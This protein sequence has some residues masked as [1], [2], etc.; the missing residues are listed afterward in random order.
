MSKIAYFSAEYSV[1]DSLP[2]YAGGLGILA[3][4]AVME[5]GSEKLDFHA[6][7]LVY[8]QAFT[9]GDDDQRPMEERL[10]DEGFCRVADVGGKPLVL[11]VRID[12]QK[13]AV[14]AWRKRFGATTLTLLDTDIAENPP[15]WRE[16]SQHLYD[17]RP[18]VIW[19]QQIVLGFGAV[20]LL[21]AMG[22]EPDIYHLNEG[23]MAMAGLA[24]AVR[25]QHLHPELT[26][27]QA[28]NAVKQQLV[29]TKHTIMHGAGLTLDRP[30]LEES[31]GP[32]LKDARG[33]IDDL[34]ALGS[35]DG[36]LLFTTKL[37]LNMVSRKCGVSR[38]HV[39][40]EAKTHPGS[41]LFPITN[42]VYVP[43]WRA[44]S[45]DEEP[46][47]Y[48]DLQ[49]W[50][51]HCANRRALL[52][53][54]RAE[55]GQKLHPDHLTVVWAR[56]MAVYKRPE[57]LITDLARLKALAAHRDRPVQFIVAGQ[58]NPVD[59]P[60]VEL[61][62]R[63]IKTAKLPE[64]AGAF[65]YLPHYNP[66]TAR[67]LVQGADL[68]LNTPQRGMEACG[69]SGMKA[70]LNGALQ[71][72]TSDGWVDEIDAAPIGWIIPEENS[73]C[74]MYDLLERQVAPLFYGLGGG[75]LPEG[76][77]V[78]MRAAIQMIEWHYN[79]GRMLQNYYDQLYAI[80]K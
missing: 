53:Y 48:S 51:A 77:L 40:M 38:I 78:K 67:L 4:D 22:E 74:A 65:A 50:E 23:H 54:V 80:A 55:T 35:D 25:H 13:I 3:G 41:P 15:R 60:G 46:L 37:L 71:L 56:R 12:D 30:S 61:M 14:A 18:G 9:P 17:G 49:L 34:M 57:L 64:L 75:E 62:N 20:A 5:A 1:A 6:F 24:V 21:E 72:S 47:K 44:V 36:K 43:R 10:I 58:A 28:L 42:G 79:A 68:W 76:W 19:H 31:L 59:G 7:G 16:L 73:A 2:I 52:E 63:V 11:Q 27:A 69:T 33:S 70:S 8:H 39:Q 66:R 26:L 29:A 32:V 45:L